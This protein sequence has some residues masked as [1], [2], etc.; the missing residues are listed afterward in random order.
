MK[1]ISL[2]TLWTNIYSRLENLMDYSIRYKHYK[3]YYISKISDPVNFFHLWISISTALLQKW[4]NNRLDRSHPTDENESF[5]QLVCTY[6]HTRDDVDRESGC[7]IDLCMRAVCRGE[8]VSSAYL[9]ERCTWRQRI[10]Q[11]GTYS[12]DW[13]N[14]VRLPGRAHAARR[15][16]LPVFYC[17]VMH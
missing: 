8:R 7:S 6:V 2:R 17:L 9:L 3:D 12:S 1:K 14:V 10:E 15:A 4:I 5:Y 16:I 13:W 11:R